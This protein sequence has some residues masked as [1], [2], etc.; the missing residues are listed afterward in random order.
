MQVLLLDESMESYLKMWRA[1][2]EEMRKR[3]LMVHINL[4]TATNYEESI[5][6]AAKLV[7]PHITLCGCFTHFGRCVYSKLENI[8]LKKAYM[9]DRR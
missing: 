6:R 8:G 2:N 7:W 4:Q 9:D 1:L 5:A 3:D